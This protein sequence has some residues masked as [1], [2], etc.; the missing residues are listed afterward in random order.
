MGAFLGNDATRVIFAGPDTLIQPQAF[1]TLALVMHELVTNAAKHG[2]LA[3]GT[4]QV[5]IAW[6]RD[7]AGNLMLDWQ[8]SGGAAVPAAI[9]SGFGSAII[10]RSIPHELGG[11]AK[12]DYAPG[13]LH[14]RFVVPTRFVLP[15]DAL[16]AVRIGSE[17][18][19]PPV[20]LAGTVLLVEDNMIIALEGED[21]L[22]EL[23]AGNVLVAGNVTDA[24]RL[25]ESETP[26]FA[27]LDI[28]LGTEMSWPVAS[29]LR[30]L[31]V[32]YVFATGY[33]NGIDF[34]LEHRQV[35]VIAKPYSKDT[36]ARLLSEA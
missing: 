15:G 22:V 7:P 25:I 10:Q 20:R 13:G 28:N 26:T 9:R 23:G 2:A 16:A 19:R 18:A 32:R 14:A 36:I 31:G 6:D 11:E 3:S 27:L 1:A 29:R 17:K 8:E 35:P 21:L 33:G 34:P 24:L 5:T 30:D 4:G 12:V